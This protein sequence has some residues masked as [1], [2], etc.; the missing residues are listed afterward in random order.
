[1]GKKLEEISNDEI[2][3]L[4]GEIK[5]KIAHY[6][7]FYF[8]LWNT[9]GYVY[10]LSRAIKRIRNTVNNSI[11]EMYA[12]KGVDG[13]K[14]IGVGGLSAAGIIEDLILGNSKEEIIKN[15]ENGKY[16]RQ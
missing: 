15:M 12:A 3:N 1:M 13:V 11:Y 7:D 2:V 6:S 8:F 10:V 14:Q 4:L 16:R 5:F 9:G